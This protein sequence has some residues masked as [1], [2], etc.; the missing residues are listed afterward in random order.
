MTGPDTLAVWVANCRTGLLGRENSQRHV[1]AEW[2]NGL[3]SIE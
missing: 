2:E 1:F 3:Q